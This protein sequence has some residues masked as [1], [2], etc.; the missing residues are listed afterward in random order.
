MR[1]VTMIRKLF[2]GLLAIV[3]GGIVCGIVGL[4]VGAEIGGNY[5]DDFTFHGLRG[6]E[7]AVRADRV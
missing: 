7:A 4:M 5:A 2:F 1:E 6:Y 3:A